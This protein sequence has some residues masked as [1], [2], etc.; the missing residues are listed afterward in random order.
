MKVL[1]K[2]YKEEQLQRALNR[3]R[4]SGKKINLKNLKIFLINGINLLRKKIKILKKLKL[5]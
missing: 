5:Y 3:V 1:K 2:D 4:L